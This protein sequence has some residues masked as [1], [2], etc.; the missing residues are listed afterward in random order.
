MTKI[1]IISNSDKDPGLEFSH[2]LVKSINKKGAIGYIACDISTCEND[3]RAGADFESDLFICT[4]G[5]GTFLRAARMLYKHRKPIMGINLGTLGFLSEVD[6]NE[7]DMK[8]D[9]IISGNYTV[10]E[11]FMLKV[12]LKKSDGG[13]FDDIAL[14]D[15]VIS[16]S[17]LSRIMQL[18]TLVNGTVVDN[19]RG[20]G[21]IISTPTGSTGYSLSAGGPIVEPDVDLFIVT[22][23]CPHTLI[24]RSFIATAERT[25][26]VEINDTYMH[27]AIMTID[28][29]TH[30]EV[31]GGDFVSIC[32]NTEKVMMLKVSDKSFFDLLRNKIHDGGIK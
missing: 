11:R 26:G 31:A 16:R 13:I 18:K 12:V 30:V 19:F 20:D 4:G 23:I 5:D 25:L 1:A 8:L 22:P 29:Q 9:D 28:G 15:V 7:I 10:Q 14:N 6:R 21:V 2:E 17:P 3:D 24:A 27:T 32:G